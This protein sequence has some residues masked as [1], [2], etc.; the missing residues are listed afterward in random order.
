[1]ISPSTVCGR[2]V[3]S[4]RVWWMLPHLS[5]PLQDIC[6]T[7]SVPPATAASADVPAAS[8]GLLS[9]R[10]QQNIIFKQL[11]RITLTSHSAALRP[12]PTGL[13]GFLQTA[14]GFLWYWR[15]E[16]VHAFSVIPHCTFR[17]WKKKR[18][19]DAGFTTECIY[20][21]TLRTLHSVN[22]II[23]LCYSFEEVNISDMHNMLKCFSYIS[24]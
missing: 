21:N 23:T 11:W 1:M 10:L 3:K 20:T 13:N 17:C 8:R 7:G 6:P 12:A 9:K 16:R 24:D 4:V 14:W 22:R 2:A 18:L 15:T 19:E 5:R